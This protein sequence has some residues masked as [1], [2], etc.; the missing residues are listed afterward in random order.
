MGSGYGVDQ[1]ERYRRALDASPAECTALLAVTT[2]SPQMGEEAVAGDPRWLG[3]VR[4]PDVC[5]ALRA[6]AHPEP[7]VG[8]AWR[9]SLD[10]LREQGD[11]A[12]WISIR[13]PSE[14]WARRDEAEGIL[15]Y[16]LG[17]LAQPTLT[18]VRER[19]GS[20]PDDEVA[21]ALVWRGQST[22]V[23]PWRNQMHVKYRVAAEVKEECFRLQFLASDG[24]PYLTVEA[25]D[26]H[27]K[28]RFDD[29]PDLDLEN[30]RRVLQE[31]GFACDND[32]YGHYWA[33]VT[34]G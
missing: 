32:G 6:L 4:W 13:L 3:S 25:R 26:N 27:P 16:L 11:L 23:S 34:P 12:P 33:R 29:D 2:R 7:L 19:L 24:K 22:V 15:R 10:V 5:D 14:G 20:G 30:A 21:A 28:E 9:A 18:M 1:L 31:E 8:A 17:E